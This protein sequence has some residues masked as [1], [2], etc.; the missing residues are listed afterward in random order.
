MCL[1]CLINRKKKKLRC[2]Q[3]ALE[4][5]KATK[6]NKTYNQFTINKV[7]KGQTSDDEELELEKRS[8]EQ[9]LIESQVKDYKRAIK[10][11]QINC[12]YKQ[13]SD[14]AEEIEAYARGSKLE[15]KQRVKNF[16][17]KTNISKSLLLD[18]SSNRVCWPQTSKFSPNGLEYLCRK[19]AATAYEIYRQKLKKR[20]IEVNLWD[21]K[22]KPKILCKSQFCRPSW[23]HLFLLPNL[24]VYSK[25]KEKKK[26]KTK[27]KRNKIRYLYSQLL[28]RQR[29]LD[30][31]SN[32]V[33]KF[34]DEA[35]TSDTS[36]NDF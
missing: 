14:K 26:I 17:E 19:D 1:R 4:Q 22:K 13:C 18:T 25:D 34:E 11:T 16:Q 32:K 33:P 3:Q 5:K 2:K 35:V 31:Y 6:K 36:G 12:N 23:K 10:C 27:K 15:W 9:Y 29:L 28:L 8:L 30:E 24:C 7:V 20:K 21:K